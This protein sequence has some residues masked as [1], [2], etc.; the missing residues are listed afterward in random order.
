MIPLHD[1]LGRLACMGNPNTGFVECVYKGHKTS[2]KL[3]IG[4]SF[5]VERQN[6]VTV[7]TRTPNNR[8]DVCSHKSTVA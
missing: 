4:E 1:C 3:E 6:V 5:T 7:I 8:F 2:T